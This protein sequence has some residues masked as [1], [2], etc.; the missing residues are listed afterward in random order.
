MTTDHE[1]E[2]DRVTKRFEDEGGRPARGANGE[3]LPAALAGISIGVEK[4]ELMVVVGPSG[5]GK[6]TTLRIVAGLEEADSG[7]VKIG[8]TSMTRVAPQ[9][10]DVAM[11]FQGYALY[12]QMTVRENIEFP[13]KMRK[14]EP[15]LRKKRADDAAELLELGRLMDRL[16]SELWGGERQRVAMG[17]AI[18]RRPRVFLFDEPLS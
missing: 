17:R 7:D 3:V 9:D 15:A 11:V 14:V 6:S 5:C 4:G 16:P 2:L 18:V 8:G 13:L 12:P 1:V 10:R